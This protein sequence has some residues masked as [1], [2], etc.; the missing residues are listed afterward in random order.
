MPGGKTHMAIGVGLGLALSAALPISSAFPWQFGLTVTL[1]TVGALAPDLDIA[2]NEL[3]ELGRSQGRHVARRLRRAGR[4]AGCVWVFI[5][6]VA[7]AFLWLAGEMISRLVEGVGF[8]IQRTTTHRGLT[9]SL[10]VTLAVVA[11]STVLSIALTPGHTA[12]WGVAWS[13]GYISH[14]LADALTLSGLKLLQPWSQRRYWL[15]PRTLRFRVG[16][17]PDALLGSVAPV[18]GLLILLLAHGLL[19]ALA[20]ALEH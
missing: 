10:V 19:D 6:H 15:V 7:G 3:E 9:H 20:I 18:I 11:V 5:T 17:W 1:A 16:T 4:R 8:C 2:D 12:W 13:A 14:L